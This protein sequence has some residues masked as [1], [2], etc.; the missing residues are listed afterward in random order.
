MAAD[1]TSLLWL[2]ILLAYGALIVASDLNYENTVDPVITQAMQCR[3]RI[4]GLS[5]AVVKDGKALL[6]KGYGLADLQNGTPVT[7]FTLFRLASITKA[8]SATLLVK[9]LQ[10]SSK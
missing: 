3:P 4:P 6:S 5:I 10:H 9:L 1:S 8:V 7:E 2:V